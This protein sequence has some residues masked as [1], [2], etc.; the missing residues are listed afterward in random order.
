M[1]PLV[2]VTGSSGHIGQIITPHLRTEGFRV[3]GMDQERK[4]DFV[5]EFIHGDLRDIA[6]VK[7]AVAGVNLVIHLGGVS[8][9]K[10]TFNDLLAPNLVGVHNVFEAMRLEGIHN[11]V[12][13]STIQAVNIFSNDVS[14]WDTS[15]N[16]PINDYG[17]LKIAAEDM[18]NIYYRMHDI[19][20]I[21]ARFG[22][23]PKNEME[24]KELASQPILWSTYLSEDDLC[25]FF[26][27]YTQKIITG[28]RVIYVVSR[29]NLQRPRFDVMATTKLFGYEPRDSFQAKKARCKRS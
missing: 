29:Q 1:K 12:L 22:W 15:Q 28:F 14:T 5:D 24:F 26:S 13:A 8:D 21:A 16:C 11:M 19:N 27:C 4:V 6:L 7:R 17:L 9:D 10:A 23:I 20:C 2:L 3:R 18:G 25:R